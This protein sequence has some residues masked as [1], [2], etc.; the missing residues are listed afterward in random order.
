[1][2]SFKSSSPGFDGLWDFSKKKGWLL[3]NQKLVSKD[4]LVNIFLRNIF[5]IL[6][7]FSILNK[8]PKDLEYVPL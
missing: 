7:I 8:S 2:W 4:W 5:Q 3:L 1:M 6:T